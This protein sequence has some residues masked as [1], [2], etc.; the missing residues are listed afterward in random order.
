MPPANTSPSIL[1]SK[2]MVTRSLSAAASAS[3]LLVEAAA[4]LAQDLDGLVDGLSVTSEV[5]RLTSTAARS[6]SFTSGRPRTRRRSRCSSGRSR[7]GDGHAGHAAGLRP[8]RRRKPG[9]LGRWTTS[10]CTEA[11]ALGHDVHRHL[12]GRKPS[13]LTVRASFFR[14]ASTSFWIAL[15]RQRQRDLAFELLRAFQQSQPWYLGSSM[16]GGARGLEP[17]TINWRQDPNLVRL[18]ISPPACQ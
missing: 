11:I 18:P 8:Q 15:R 3:S 9:R 1:P 14:R 4:L 5:T 10:Y 16:V 13:V 2:S 7:P 12:A 6:P 17:H